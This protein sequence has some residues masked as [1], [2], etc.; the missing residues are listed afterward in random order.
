LGSIQPLAFANRF[1]SL[2]SLAPMKTRSHLPRGC[3][4]T[5]SV[6][7]CL[8]SFMKDGSSRFTTATLEPAFTPSL[9]SKGLVETAS[10]ITF[11]FSTQRPEH[12]HAQQPS[13]VSPCDGE[14]DQ[15]DDV[16]NPV[17]EQK[18]K[19]DERTENDRACDTPTH[20]A[21][22]DRSGAGCLQTSTT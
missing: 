21:D 10:A 18:T 1:K 8:N 14:N 11:L 13:R 5:T 16:V 20:G 7:R 15:R 19:R 6:V 22:Q 3:P 12:D 2:A 9:S 17:R 4:T